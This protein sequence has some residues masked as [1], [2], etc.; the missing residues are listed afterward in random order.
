MDAI[1]TERLA[2]VHPELARR[3]L[4]LYAM[5]ESEF[6]ITQGLRSW[7]EQANLYAQG[8]TAPGEIVTNAQPGYSFHCFGLACDFVPMAN[9]QPIWDTQ[10]PEWKHIIDL[11][12]SC[13]LVS[14]STWIH[15][16][17]WP[18][19]QPSELP[20]TPT[21]TD[22]QDF[23]EAGISAVWENYAAKLLST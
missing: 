6:R 2:V 13:G 10:Q 17:D 7:Q 5:A 12:P 3:I 14:G 1:S 22:R 11:A 20:I 19:L 18:H 9:G 8:R 4:Q 21:D 23:I 15:F 16:P